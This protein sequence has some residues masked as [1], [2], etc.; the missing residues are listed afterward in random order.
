[1]EHLSE[2][3]IQ[4]ETMV[5]LRSVTITYIMYMKINTTRILA[6]VDKFFFF[7]FCFHL[8]FYY[9]TVYITYLCLFPWP[10]SWEREEVVLVLDWNFW[11]V[12][13]HLL[14]LLIESE[15]EGNWKVRLNA[16]L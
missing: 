9:L 4:L 5:T 14:N 8:E 2:A 6:R 12:W 1:M 11:F 15:G 16:L 7:L 3:L 13:A 10:L